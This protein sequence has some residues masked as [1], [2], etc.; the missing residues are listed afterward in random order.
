M[1]PHGQKDPEAKGPDPRDTQAKWFGLVIAMLL[2][3]IAV[4]LI[5]R[6]LG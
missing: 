2:G 4:Q 5:K 1:Q 6:W 3:V